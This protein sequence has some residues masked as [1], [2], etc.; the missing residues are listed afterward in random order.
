MSPNR[1][2]SI[3]AVVA[4]CP[5]NWS[6]RLK[7]WSSRGSRRPSIW[8]RV[9]ARADPART[10]V[11]ARRYRLRE[12]RQSAGSSRSASFPVP[13]APSGGYRVLLSPDQVSLRDQSRVLEDLD[14]EHAGDESADVR[15]HRHA[16]RDARIDR[17]G[18]GVQDLQGEP[19]Q[20]N[21]PRRDPEHFEED[22][23]DEQHVYPHTRVQHEI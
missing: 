4:R 21:D 14:Q 8:L 15:P 12:T 2:S 22:D 7:N 1:L 6:K 11:R 13:P 18:V 10:W 9:A 3:L 23:E 17:R 16:A 5:A 20:E 19:I